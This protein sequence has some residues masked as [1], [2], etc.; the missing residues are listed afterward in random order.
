MDYYAILGV[1]RGANAADIKR[2]YRRLARRHHPGINP[3]DPAAEALFQ[4]IAE[5]YATLLDPERRQRYDAAGTRRAEGDRRVFEFAGF[6]FAVAAHGPQAATFAELFAD[7]LHP[8]PP[9][10]TGT[11]EPGA[12]LHASLSISF[13]DALRG[14][15]RHLMVMRQVDCAAC[16]GAGDVQTP[17]V[18]CPHCRGAGTVRWARG[19]M[20]FTNACAPCAGT[21]RES[22]RRCAGCAGQ[23]RSVRS[24]TIGVRMPAGV[25][26]G[27]RLRVP[28][29]GHAGR[30]GARNGHLYVDVGVRT[31]RAVRR[32]GDDLHMIVPVAVHE[33]SLGARIEVPSIDGPVRVKL[34]AGTQAGQRFRVTGLGA[35]SP[36]GSRGDLFVEVQLAV[37][38]LADE[39]SKELMREF[40]RLNP[41]DVRQ[42][43]AESFKSEG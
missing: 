35:P 23:G 36:G 16:H 38:P 25:R 34:P 41:H 7:V 4:R 1:Q 18:R 22:S 9:S 14:V 10:D 43:F 24:E 21:G 39:R 29:R 37:R 33:A 17:D 6:D 26:D 20:V 15:E 27:A 30:H 8:V 13:E 42:A 12:D 11:S 32:E 40:A 28:E 3:G 31:H 5:A 2:A 19:H